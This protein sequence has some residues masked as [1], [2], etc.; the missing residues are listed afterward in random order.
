MRSGIGRGHR[1]TRKEKDRATLPYRRTK[2]IEETDSQ[3]LGKGR[4]NQNARQEDTRYIY[5]RDRKSRQ[6]KYARQLLI[7]G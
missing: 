4:K 3:R 5:D 6:V 7:L 2:E 1:Y